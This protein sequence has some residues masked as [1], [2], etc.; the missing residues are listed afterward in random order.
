MID[1]P[2]AITRRIGI[3]QVI[4]VFILLLPQAI[5]LPSNA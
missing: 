4:R 5:S 2:F 1:Y 3:V